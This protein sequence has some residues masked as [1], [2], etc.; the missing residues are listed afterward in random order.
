MRR[1]LT[2][3]WAA[4]LFGVCLFFGTL[5]AQDSGESSAPQKAQQDTAATEQSGGDA[6]AGVG[7][8]LTKTT[9]QS[10]RSAE[11]WGRKI[12]L[13]PDT[14]FFIS[15][16]LNFA[17][18]VVFFYVILKSKL[19]QAFR[20][21]TAAIQKGIKEAQAASADAARR[22]KDIEARLSKLDGEVA[23]IRAS[24]EREAAAEEERIRQATEQDRQK[25]VEAAEAEIAAIARNARR[26][27]KGYAA[28]LAVDLAAR[29]I[30]VDEPTDQALVRDFVGQLGKD[31]K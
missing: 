30:R 24:A 23:E 10:A 22:L 7:N 13:G 17:G 15:I 3:R 19:P 21:R 27:L 8:I 4:I 6:S 28:S 12:G 14:S 29:E 25:V 18:I 31:G 26:E 2:V 9:E 1:Q 16:F 20:E 5:A 11:K